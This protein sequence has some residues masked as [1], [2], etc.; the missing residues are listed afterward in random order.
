LCITPKLAITVKTKTNA[1]ALILALKSQTHL[2]TQNFSFA[3]EN[4]QSRKKFSTKNF[5]GH[6]FTDSD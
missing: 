2:Q 4:I 3:K 5:K 1:N 6:E